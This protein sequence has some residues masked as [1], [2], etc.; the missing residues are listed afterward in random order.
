ME[1]LDSFVFFKMLHLLL[2]SFT[3]L[4][5]AFTPIALPLS[6]SLS[7]REASINAS[8][9]PALTLDIPIDHY[10]DSDTRTYSNRFWINA[11]Y[12]KPGGPVIYFDAG[13][14]N[15]HPLVPY[16]LAEAAGPSAIMTLARR[17]GYL[18]MSKMRS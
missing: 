1:H 8:D 16:F 7:R 2:L 5:F 9:Y 15:A 13:E 3:A 11:T 12:Y 17:H 18:T 4:A 6:G 14:Q 10:N